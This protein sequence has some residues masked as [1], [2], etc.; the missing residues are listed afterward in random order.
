MGA[1]PLGAALHA[2]G[3][4]RGLGTLAVGEIDCGWKTGRDR[5]D[6]GA[7]PPGPALRTGAAWRRCDRDAMGGAGSD[8]E[9]RLGH[10]YVNADT[11]S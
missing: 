11:H 1:T 8:K 10:G 7:S 4:Q 9:G 5:D 6:G 2:G 3:E